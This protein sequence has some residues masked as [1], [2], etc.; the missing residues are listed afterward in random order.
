MNDIME[1]LRNDPRY[2]R[3]VKTD[4]NAKL[5]ASTVDFLRAQAAI[6]N[7]PLVDAEVDRA[8]QISEH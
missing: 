7:D 8:V 3:P 4:E 2:I 5:S 6:F 1:L